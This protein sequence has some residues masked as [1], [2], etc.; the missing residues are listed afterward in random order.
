MKTKFLVIAVL[1]LLLV[2]ACQTDSDDTFDSETSLKEIPL[3]QPIYVDLGNTS[4]SV[5]MKTASGEKMEVVLYMAEY[6]TAENSEEMGNTI[7]FNNRGNKQLFADFVP[8]VYLPY[9]PKTT[10]DITYYVDISRPSTD[11]APSSSAGAIRGAMTTWDEATCSNLGITEVPY[12]V[13]AGFIAG[14]Y[15]Y[16]PFVDPIGGWVADV[17][18]AG[19]MSSTSEFFNDRRLGFPP[20][21]STFILVSHPLK[22]TLNKL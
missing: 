10:N 13:P 3:K 9:V 22:N 20:N 18:H 6:I 21:G 2:F 14:L 8:D 1:T 15:G 16:G 11:M 19:W 12:G 5:S 4:Q 17:V 7:F